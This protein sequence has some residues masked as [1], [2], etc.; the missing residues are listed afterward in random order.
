MSLAIA[1]ATVIVAAENEIAR[2]DS[3]MAVKNA[4]VTN[5]VKWIDG[6]DLPIEG[7]A[8]D[9]VEH[10]YDRLIAE[11]WKDLYFL[12]KEGMLGYDGE[13]TVDGAHPNDIGMVYMAEV[14]GK[15]V[16]KALKLH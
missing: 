1:F 12:S 9:D 10:Y 16:K 2:Y 14:Y 4:V 7:C 5:G 6:K 11:G 8:F 13:G 3:N 15:A